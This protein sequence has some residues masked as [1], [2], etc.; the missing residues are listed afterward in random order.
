M[1]SLHYQDG[2]VPQALLLIFKLAGHSFYLIMGNIDSSGVLPVIRTLV[3]F[4]SRLITEYMPRRLWLACSSLA[5]G[6][7]SFELHR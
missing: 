2:A 5:G 4:A 3:K 6:I 7:M 1:S